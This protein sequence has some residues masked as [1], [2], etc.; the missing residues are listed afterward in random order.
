MTYIRTVNGMEMNFLPSVDVAPLQT[1]LLARQQR[2]SVEAPSMLGF[3]VDLNTNL[4]LMH[5]AGVMELS[6][7][8]MTVFTLRAS[9]GRNFTLTATSRP[10]GV[11]ANLVRTVCVTLSAEDVGR[12]QDLSICTARFGG[13][14]GYF[15]SQLIS[16]YNGRE[17]EDVSPSNSL[18][19]SYKN[20]YDNKTVD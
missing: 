17:V 2:A 7:L 20:Q 15:T 16:D 14:S 18:A 1:P 9:Q 8:D 5:F 19:V 4:L 13:C 10:I 3:D 11:L 6:S 12:I